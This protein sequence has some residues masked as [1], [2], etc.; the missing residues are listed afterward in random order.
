MAIRRDEGP[1]ARQRTA[2][3]ALYFNTASPEGP[4]EA[5]VAVLHGYADYAARYGHVLDAWAERAIA[6]VAIDMRGHGHAEGKRG[7]CE[8]FA[9]YLDDVSELVHLM[10]ER[11]PG[12]PA[13][14]F[15]HSFGGLVAA[16]AVLDQPSGWS[17]L[18][19]SGPYFGLSLHV[20]PLKLLAG[21]I[22]SRLVPALGVPSELRGSDLTHDAVRARAYDE[23]PLVFK[24]ATARWFSEAGAA[25][26]SALLRAPS[27]KLPLYLV[28]G[29]DD[30]VAKVE[31]ARQF[32]DAAGSTD[33][34][35]DLREGL[36]HEVLNE[37]EWRSIADS[38][39]DFVL[40]HK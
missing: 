37:P 30:H 14:L 13:F 16:S 24:K 31:S 21:K 39:A 38:I 34:T 6:S 12:V 33:K 17:G 8:R 9:E 27:L 23:D 10:G 22:A 19:L 7:F 5:V 20:P 18:V 36:L 40:A 28:M 15:G 32:F 35:W 25:Q 4:P 26:A 3:P 1:L 2:G 11:A 29:K